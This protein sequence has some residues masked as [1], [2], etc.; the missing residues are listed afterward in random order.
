VKRATVAP[1]TYVNI[2]GRWRN[3]IEPVFG[4][5]Q[6]ASIRPIDVRK[7]V[8]SMLDAG[9]AP[10]TARKVLQVLAQIFRS[11]EIDRLIARSPIIGIE[12]PRSAAADEMD[13]LAAAEVERL[14]RCIDSRYRALIFTAAYCGL[15]AE[16]SVICG[17]TASISSGAASRYA[18]HSPRS[19][20]GSSKGRQRRAGSVR[21]SSLASSLPC[22]PITCRSTRR[23]GTCSRHVTAGLCGTATSCAATTTLQSL[24]PSS[25][26]DFVS[27]ISVTH[28]P[29]C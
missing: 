6:L 9:M 14:A 23:A 10:D 13:F 2:E 19:A 20:D 28:A 18:A 25:S 15:R 5:H 11:A 3:H 16:S 21:S 24:V 22:W 12:L 29:R 4:E 7:W 17:S 1:R 26:R 8:A 27:T